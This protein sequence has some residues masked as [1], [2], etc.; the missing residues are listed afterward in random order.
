[1]ENRSPAASSGGDEEARPASFEAF[2]AD[3]ATRKPSAH[4]VKAYRQDF[5]AIATVI[6]G[7]EQP[8]ERIR[9]SASRPI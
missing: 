5:D 3:R 7:D 4:T 6:V 1:V 8:V 9:L 2:L